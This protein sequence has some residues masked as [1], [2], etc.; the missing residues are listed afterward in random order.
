MCF[1]EFAL[2]RITLTPFLEKN[3]N[4]EVNEHNLLVL[5]READQKSTDISHIRKVLVSKEKAGCVGGQIN[6][7]YIWLFN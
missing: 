5:T 2:R 7:T 1:V 4:T 6:N 3:N